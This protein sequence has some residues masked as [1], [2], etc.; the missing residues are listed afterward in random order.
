MRKFGAQATSG[1]YEG[2][3]GNQDPTAEPDV[4][5]ALLLF[6]IAL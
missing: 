3:T 4:C 2:L 5:S 6:Y 1:L